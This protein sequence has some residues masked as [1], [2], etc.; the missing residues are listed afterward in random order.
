MN[1]CTLPLRE[2]RTVNGLSLDE[3]AAWLCVHKTTV[4]RIESGELPVDADMVE[5]IEAVTG[6]SV[7]AGEIHSVR[8]NWLKEH[9]PEK[10][11]T[12][13]PGAFRSEEAA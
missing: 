6:G 2:F 10:F 9:R 13:L 3:M 12:P 11:V 4:M 1:N 7:S 5:R 8:L